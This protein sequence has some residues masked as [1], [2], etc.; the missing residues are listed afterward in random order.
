MNPSNSTDAASRMAIWVQRVLG[1]AV[2][3]GGIG[4]VFGRGPGLAAEMQVTALA[5]AT[6]QLV[7]VVWWFAGGCMLLLGLRLGLD[8][9]QAQ[10]GRLLPGLGAFYAAFGLV[11][12]LWSNQPFFWIF[13]ALGIPGLALWGW[14]RGRF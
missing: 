11:A 4:H 5:P 9:A 1:A 10:V 13:V 6:Q 7:L 14:R 2:A 8:A 12:V 3:L